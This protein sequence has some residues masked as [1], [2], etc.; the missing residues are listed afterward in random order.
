M[1]CM[2]GVTA[3]GAIVLLSV[4][5]ARRAPGPET[6]PAAAPEEVMTKMAFKLSSPAFQENARIP[7]RY[8]ADGADVS[9]ALSWEKPPQGTASLALIMDD[10]DAPRGTWVH[11]VLY[12]LP[13]ARTDLPEGVA[14]Q[15]TLPELGGAR[16]GLNDFGKVGY[17]G[18]APPHGPAHHYRFTLYALDAP[19]KLPER[20]RKPDV[21][22]A[23]QGHTLGQAR[24]V[25]IYSR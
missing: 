24:L 5:C 15:K 4:G 7:A 12:D 1:R 8:T 18:P 23:M 25:G 14:P 6:Q 20:A 10:P 16:Q 2:A 21:E 9:P 13:A 22:K 17:G 3:L 11:W 19:L